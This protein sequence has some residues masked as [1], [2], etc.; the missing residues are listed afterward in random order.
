[1]ARLQRSGTRL[2]PRLA[3]WEATVAVEP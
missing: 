3:V 2:T 1:M